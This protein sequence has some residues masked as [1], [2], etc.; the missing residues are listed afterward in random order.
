[1]AIRVSWKIAP[2]ISDTI[3]LGGRRCAAAPSSSAFPM[4]S[5][6][7]SP[8]QER[9]N[10]SLDSSLGAILIGT[11]I[12]ILMYG[13]TLHQ[14]YLYAT[15]YS[16]DP[17][18]LKLAVYATI[19]LETVHMG[20]CCHTCYFYLVTNYFNPGALGST[21][22]SLQLLS[23]PTSL[24]IVTSQ[25][26]FA[27]RAYVFAKRLYYKVLVIVAVVLMLLELGFGVASAVMQIRT[28][29]SDTA[30]ES[31]LIWM[32][33]CVSSLAACADVIL[34]T[35]LIIALRQ[36]R[37]GRKRT[38]SI[39][40]VLALYTV[41]TGLITSMTMVSLFLIIVIRRSAYGAYVAVSIIGTKFYAI[42]LLTALN[43][44][45]SLRDRARG[46][47]EGTEIFGTEMGSRS[48][49]NAAVS[50][51]L[52]MDSNSNGDTVSLE[53]GAHK[54]G[55]GPRRGHEDALLES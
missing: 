15:I 33:A 2:T 36:S 4:S 30:G 52:R 1:M 46:H 32:S 27:R 35:V 21:P 42:S 12:G 48:R 17:V 10:I 49:A 23:V 25:A 43:S 53:T 13:V 7:L 34:S 9:L 41:A 29:K 22:L 31:S 45:Q 20:F 26:F 11:F 6:V 55:V 24:V 5:S 19:L 8:V 44:R 47:L 14:V 3:S 50:L 51:E 37:G 16:S 28:V 54:H 18:R 39:L 38:D 40:D